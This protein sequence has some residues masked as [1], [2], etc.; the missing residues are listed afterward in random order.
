MPIAADYL[1]LFPVTANGQHVAL[2]GATGQLPCRN[3]A[4][5]AIATAAV[6]HLRS[7]SVPSRDAWCAAFADVALAA[8][9]ADRD[10]ARSTL[11]LLWARTTGDA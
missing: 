2:F 10:R 1:G 4:A 5:V 9:D 6:E 3:A 7:A 8:T 11:A